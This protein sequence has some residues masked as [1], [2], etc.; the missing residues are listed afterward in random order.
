[1]KIWK[2]I[3]VNALLIL[4]LGIFS[5]EDPNTPGT[6]YTVTVTGRVVR[7]L[8]SSGIDS[9]V[10]RLG[11]PLKRDTTSSDG[12]FTIKAVSK[13][14]NTISTIVTLSHMNIAYYE[15]T[16]AVSYSRT[17]NTIDLGEL[18][19]RG[20]VAGLDS[21]I[22]GRP[23]FRP[24]VV[25]F[26][27]S[28]FPL[29]SIKGAG[30]DITS[31]TF[32]V[33]DSLGNPVDENNKA[34]VAFKLVTAPDNAVVLSRTSAVTNSIGQVVVQLSA[35]QK[36]GIAQVQAVYI[37][38]V[39][40]DTIK[41]PVVSVTIA[42][43][44]PVI[45]RFALGSDKSN[46]AGLVKYN[47]RN[48]ITAMVADT[49]G[50]PVQRGTKVY[51]TSTAG[52]I[53]SEA[54]TNDNGLASVEL[55]TGPPAPAGGLAVITATVGTPGTPNTGALT[56]KIVDESVII[57]GL[58]N[59]K[60]TAPSVNS[61]FAGVNAPTAT[62]TKSVN[63][64]FTG[65]PRV[66]SPDSAFIVQPFGTKNIQFTVDDLNGNPMSQGSVIRVYG[67][68][69][70]TV[71]AELTGDLLYTMPDTYDRSFTKFNVTLKDKR[72]KNLNT[73][74]PVGITVEVTGENGSLKKTFSGFL[75][76]AVA[77]SGKVGSIAIVNPAVDTL[78]ATGA[79]SPNS[80]VIQARVLTA[81]GLASPGVPVNF[82]IVKSVDG[83][84]YLSSS[85]ATTNGSGIASV[86][87]YSGIRSGLVQVQTSVKKDS[88][89]VSSD[90]K[91]VYIKTGK[92]TTLSLVSSSA[93]SLSVKGGG[94]TE[95]AVLVFEA[96]D[97]LGNT[98]DGTNTT[99][100]SFT[101]HGDTSGARI[102]PSVTKADPNTGRVTALLSAGVQSGIIQVTAS[103]GTV[104]SSAVQFAVSGGL[105]SQSQF[106]LSVPK[107][108][109]SVLTEKTTDISIIAGDAYGNPAKAGTLINFKTNGGL[110][111]ASAVTTATGAASATL[112]IVNPQPPAGIAT[113]EARTF[114]VGG[115]TVRDTQTV[116]FSR[117]ALISEVSGPYANFEIEDGLSKTFQYS[118]SDINGNPVAQDNVITVE[119][120][121]S[122]A[123][124]I[125]LTGDINVKTLDA[126]TP[127]VG[128]TLFTF[129]A[130]DSVKDE[131]Q[132]PKVLGFV[133]KV[134]GPNTSGVVS[135]TMD[136]TLKG[137]AGAGN[138]GN[139]ASVTYI[140]SSKD[141][142]FVANAGSPTTDTITF[143]VRSLS[144]Q[145]VKNAAV[146]FFLPQAL[147]ASEFLSPSFAI[148]DDS[149]DVKVV[150]HS[151]IKAGVLKVEAKV[152]AGASSVTSQQV[153]VYV[154]TGPL[155]SIAL[156]NID[157]NELSVRGVGGE[158]NATVTYEARDLLGN[159][160]DFANQTKL[161]FGFI[162]VA[163][164]DEE[165][166][167]DSAV[168]N[169]FTGRVSVNVSSGTRSTVLQVFARN[170]AGTIK[171]SPVPI[172]VHGGFVVDSLFTFTNIVR[173]IS[174]KEK[175]PV[176]ITMSLGDRY[177]NPVK[178]GTA[179]YFESQVG[180]IKASAF[181]DNQGIVATTVTPAE[182]LGLRKITASTVGESG[183]S[184]N[185]LLKK[186]LSVL[187]SG[188]P[189]ITVPSDTVVIFDGGART[190][191]YKIADASKNP[192]S[193]EHA[194]TA[195]ISG[196]VAGELRLTGDNTFT[197]LDITDTSLT[198]YE[199]TIAD[200]QPLAGTG[201]TFAVTITVDG[202]TGK[203]SKTFYGKLYSP[204]NIVVPPSA[205][206]PAQIAFI[207]ST[208]TDLSVAGVG[209]LENALLTYEVRDSLGVPIDKNKRT[210][211]TYSMQFFP[212]SFVGGGTSP[213]VI[214]TID[215]TD[216]Q[217]KLRVSVVSGTQAGNMQIVVRIQV[218]SNIITSQPVKITIHAGF[219]DQKHFTI[220]PSR[221]S[222]LGN[223]MYN[224]VP[225]TV[226][227][228]D[229]FSNPVAT[230]TAIYFHSQAGVIQTGAGFNAYTNTSGRASV[231]LMTVNPKPDAA[232]FAY[233]P[234]SGPYA[235]SIGGRL[236][237]HW[238]YAQTQGNYGKQVIDS[239]LV[240]QCASP[241]TVTGV[242][243][244]T[245]AVA[246][247]GSSA[248]ISITIK[249]GNGNPLPE[250]TVIGVSLTYD[251]GT[252][253]SVS[254]GL[255]SLSSTTISSGSIFP[256][257]GVTD[258]TFKVN[259]LTSGGSALNSS[260]TVN[261]VATTPSTNGASQVFLTKSMSFTAKVQ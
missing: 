140:R 117:E 250:G 193:S 154:K 144:Q 129:T 170:A 138:E 80:V 136:G 167:P 106:T 78:V 79:G 15:T 210:V 97:S 90:V 191:N 96:K 194:V 162:G 230:G 59:K 240:L 120:Y 195:T 174:S 3:S 134:S 208:A 7:L 241:I 143:R 71:G 118:V 123:A 221:F 46:V 178:P 201:G 133:I 83:G 258:F 254:G 67:V 259:D 48:T 172:V 70:D 128:R 63:V 150:V 132:G 107:K 28:T 85:N 190:I 249:D 183:G 84:E 137:G 257:A 19:M 24:K 49:F 244:S 156:V 141:T 186:E 160:L 226:T 114:G 66:T 253:F 176:P 169:P 87:L 20:V 95:S 33:R 197:T 247:G 192:I 35:G 42:G 177:G 21:Q 213:R 115:V 57:K 180:I 243:S 126:K 51:F 32:E 53:P 98:V 77:D 184:V 127:G 203:T 179:V 30:N 88:L 37:D 187:M 237:Y 26:L 74:V 151:G 44:L 94:G 101:L 233:L 108:N 260:C 14:D 234:S 64:L 89:S 206:E 99:N 68:G 207:S 10:V 18:K 252:A 124:N 215:S 232:P 152:T 182:V 159:A 248:D 202:V 211:A 163:G 216:D 204:N 236:G 52:T 25:T 139:V 158:E 122:G 22:T 69:L 256:G 239:V 251:A 43:G 219:A 31:L 55:I 246:Q 50:N 9:V 100:V 157:R 65:A 199:L 242:P 54:T 200:L 5:C 153:P 6:E 165:V 231:N 116:V 38:T 131:G 91:S 181:T 238:V 188:V 223:T 155:H 61:K 17:N 225:F 82:A 209:A 161:Y 29:I 255:S 47:V 34:L 147:S 245:I 121:G 119:A 171:S 36:A 103:S 11:N 217:G 173:N 229:T 222:F 125:Q 105:P 8:N 76:S 72:T 166:N 185:V 2:R 212:N 75:T 112:Q 146:Q 189:V 218:G 12:S 227:V 214:P 93:T 110:I 220:Q 60:N 198:N 62:I 1:M 27:R 130:R 81:S 113:I 86:T 39:R 4:A 56:E 145:P 235:A 175:T 148:S 196:S 142:I 23:S 164:N 58:R 224:E 104:V 261:I 135:H 16:Y 168:T 92:V 149:G 109:Y 228:G 45:S 205:R 40:I 13:E 111:A 73:N 102:N 41:S